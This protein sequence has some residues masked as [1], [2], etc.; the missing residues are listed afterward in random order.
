MP[1]PLGHGDFA[2][3]RRHGE[4]PQR[5]TPGAAADDPPYRTGFL[6]ILTE[7][8]VERLHR[9]P[10]RSGV[11]AGEDGDRI[12]VNPGRVGPQNVPGADPGG[13][14]GDLAD[15]DNLA[16]GHH[17]F[18]EAVFRGGI[19]GEKMPAVRGTPLLVGLGLGEPGGLLFGQDPQCLKG[20]LGRL[21]PERSGKNN[22]QKE[23]FHSP[24]HRRRPIGAAGA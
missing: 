21:R 6:R 23:S 22:R 15:G 3:A 5:I 13:E 2:Q 14:L 19:V 12:G 7:L 24:P 4:F 10:Q 18:P 20:R 16:V 11:I 17:V 8:V 9:N 1:E